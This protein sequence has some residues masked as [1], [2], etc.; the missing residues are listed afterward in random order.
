VFSSIIEIGLLLEKIHLIALFYFLLVV[1]CCGGG[2]QANRSNQLQ[3]PSVDYKSGLKNNGTRGH[4]VGDIARDFKV[5]TI[6]GNEV[7]MSTYTGQS[8]VIYFFTTW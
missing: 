2:Y 1:V 4:E 8:L 7:M 6:A 5:T 3:E